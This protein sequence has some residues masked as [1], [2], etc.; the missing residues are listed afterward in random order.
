[1]KITDAIGNIDTSAL[2]V[3]RTPCGKAQ[4]SGKLRIELNAD[5]FVY[6]EKPLEIEFVRGNPVI[7][8]RVGAISDAAICI[9]HWRHPTEAKL[10]RHA[11][12][13]TNSSPTAAQLA[14]KE[15]GPVGNIT[16]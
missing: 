5:I 7:E 8:E 15:S 9:S 13:I 2:V 6:G 10:D 14:A 16:T 12:T 11:I 4:V 1:M 3:E